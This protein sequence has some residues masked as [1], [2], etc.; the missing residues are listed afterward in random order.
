LISPLPTIA[1][2][3][4]QALMNA[5]LKYRIYG[6]TKFYQRTEIKNAL[7]YLRLIHNENDDD[8]CRRVINFPARSIGKS[9]LDKIEKGARANQCSLFTYI[10]TDAS[11]CKQKKIKDFI[12]LIRQCQRILVNNERTMPLHEQAVYVFEQSGLMASYKRKQEAERLEN[13]SEL[14]NAMEQFSQLHHTDDLTEYLSV[15]ALVEHRTSTVHAENVCRRLGHEQYSR[16]PIRHIGRNR[17]DTDD[18]CS[19]C[20]RTR[21]SLCVHR[22]PR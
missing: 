2:E 1:R 20:Q 10:Q 9:T 5:G 19:W 22:W 6:G 8:A 17:T 12:E 18:D 11:L 7:A 16:R 15:I 13:L 4:E 14:C 21:I 3:F